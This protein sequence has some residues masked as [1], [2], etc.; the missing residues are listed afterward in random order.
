MPGGFPL[1]LELAGGQ[2]YGVDLTGIRGSA[3]LHCNSGTAGVF[4]SWVQIVGAT[5]YDACWI[6][7]YLNWGASNSQAVQI[8]VG[9]GASGSERIILN[10]LMLGQFNG[11]AS[12]NCYGF[13]ICIP[14]G[15]A[16]S[17]QAAASNTTNETVYAYFQL[18]DGGFSGME[19]CAGVDAIGVTSGHG[20]HILSTPSAKSSFAQMTAATVRDY[21][22][23]YMALDT[24]TVNSGY[25]TQNIVW[26]LAIGGAGAEVIIVP[27]TTSAFS[28]S[29]T[30]SNT[31]VVGPL[32]IP[33]PAGSRISWR[34]Q[35]N[36]G[37][38]HDY[39][40]TVLAMY[41]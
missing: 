14:A 8:N 32:F 6:N 35:D 12:V 38:A 18:F 10:N 15:T 30:Y 36:A 37:V 40:L 16:V 31:A 1:G 27:D 19:G 2:S 39:G 17:A 9:I 3:T 28:A 4:G 24:G 33:I 34:I 20:T 5:T 23:F 25:A 22:G 21:M 41:Q 7:V 29:A 11:N 26:D 13:P